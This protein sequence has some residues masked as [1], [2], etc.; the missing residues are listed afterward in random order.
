MATN[1]TVKNSIQL[2]A[3]DYKERN[4]MFDMGKQ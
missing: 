1:D 3:R 4:E 2:L